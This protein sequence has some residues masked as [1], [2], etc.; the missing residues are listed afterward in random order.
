MS[1]SDWVTDEH[2]LCGCASHMLTSHQAEAVAAQE[3]VQTEIAE[4]NFQ[5]INACTCCLVA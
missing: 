4:V 2:A 5:V 1:Q 3:H